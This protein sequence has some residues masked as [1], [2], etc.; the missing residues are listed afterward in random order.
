MSIFKRNVECEKCGLL[1]YR[2]S[3]QM[4]RETDYDN[5][6]YYFGPSVRDLFYCKNHKVPYNYIEIKNYDTYYFKKEVEVDKKGKLT[7]I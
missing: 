2:D 4:V 1:C 7:S 5:T 6:D 3:A